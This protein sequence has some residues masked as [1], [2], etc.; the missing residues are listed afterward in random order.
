M[1]DWAAPFYSNYRGATEDSEN[2]WSYVLYSLRSSVAGSRI[3]LP[4]GSSRRPRTLR[5]P[6]RDVPE[7]STLGSLVEGQ[8]AAGRSGVL[9]GERVEGGLPF[10]GHSG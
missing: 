2:D 5:V 1:Q 8:L 6:R 10:A 9:Q 7:F 4:L 3:H